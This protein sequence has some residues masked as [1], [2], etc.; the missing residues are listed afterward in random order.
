MAVR[1]K[2][3][4]DARV[5]LASGTMAASANGA[6]RRLPGLND[7][8]GLA[9]VLDVTADESTA[10]DKLDVYVQTKLDLTNWVDV[11]HF[12][13]HDGNVGAKRY[14]TKIL[15]GGAEAEFEVSAALA[16]AS[17]RDLIGDE[18]RVRVVV[19]DDSGSAT[20]TFSVYA[21]PM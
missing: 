20:F 5:L 6:S 19:T 9:F 3:D 1:D 7:V 18:W 15:A 11:V 8:Q 14:V 17:V 10:A 16:E 12:T 4:D 13:Q 2:Y 21:C